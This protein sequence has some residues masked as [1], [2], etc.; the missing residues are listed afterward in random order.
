MRRSIRELHG[1]NHEESEREHMSMHAVSISGYLRFTCPL[2][3]GKCNS[4]RR[5]RS[6]FITTQRK[7][8][9]TSCNAEHTELSSGSAPSPLRRRNNETH[10]KCHPIPS[11]P[12]SRA[13][14]MTASRM[15]SV[16]RWCSRRQ[17]VAL[18]PRRREKRAYAATPF[19]LIPAVTRMQGTRQPNPNTV[20]GHDTHTH[21]LPSLALFNVLDT[22][23]LV[24][25]DLAGLELSCP[26]QN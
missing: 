4:N 21:D 24:G 19:C 1:G 14:A 11:M 17:T 20:V 25:R 18:A 2:S 5:A 13:M 12:S 3:S 7:G 22:E 23:A 10:G 26:P 9:P 6:R 15:L 8:Q 16:W